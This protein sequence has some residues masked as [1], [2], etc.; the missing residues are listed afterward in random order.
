MEHEQFLTH[1]E[2]ERLLGVAKST[3]RSMVKNGEFPQ[4]IR[5]GARRIAW[6]SSDYEAWVA[7]RKAERV[8]P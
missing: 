6:A 5:I 2:V 1:R 3:L 8:L 7:E 4:P